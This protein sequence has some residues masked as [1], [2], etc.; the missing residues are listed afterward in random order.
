MRNPWQELPSVPPFVAPIDAEL[1]SRARFTS[2]LKLDLLPQPWTGNP[3]SAQVFMLA[4]NPGF[5]PNDYIELSNPDY[6]EQW[7]LALSFQT[8]TPFYF[9]DPAF[10]DT[11]GYRGWARRLR[12]LIEVVG[13]EAVGAKVMCIEHFP[14][15]SVR[16]A[17]L[18]V[19]LPSQLYSFELVREAIRQR[20]QVVIMRSERVWLESVPELRSYPNIR[21][22]NH[23]NP[24][25]SRAQMSG[26]ESGG[27]WLLCSCKQTS[28]SPATTLFSCRVTYALVSIGSSSLRRPYPLSCT[29][30]I[31]RVFLAIQH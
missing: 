29:I 20:K 5:S 27:L 2:E 21:L 22:S 15:K 7:R 12:E 23:Q 19:T 3:N 8:R 16:Y 13:I 17:P 4:L 26:E 9:L 25:L 30:A 11:G 6:A 24:Y 14:Y 31:L 18:G 1:L 10:K 28:P